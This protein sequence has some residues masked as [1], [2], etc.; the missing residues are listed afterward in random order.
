MITLFREQIITITFDAAK[1]MISD[2]GKYN[3][4]LMQ[5]LHDKLH[6]FDVRNLVTFKLAVTVH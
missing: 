4:R 2:T 3:C 6:W 5:L 1:H